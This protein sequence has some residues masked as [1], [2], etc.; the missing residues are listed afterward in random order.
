[1][2]K[3]YP[4]CLHFRR[5]NISITCQGYVVPCCLFMELDNFEQLKTLLGDKIDQLHISN[6]K[7]EDILKSEAAD[8]IK[9]TYENQPLDRCVKSCSQ[10]I[11]LDMTPAGG[12]EEIV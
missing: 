1:M 5:Q 4:R 3:I 9:N 7:I 8:L 2:N 11:R 6:G 10:P 12:H